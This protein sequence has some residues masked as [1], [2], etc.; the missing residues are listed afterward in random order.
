[1]VT[2]A[3]PYREVVDYLAIHRDQVDAVM[4]TLSYVDGTVFA[5][6][7]TAPALLTVALMDATCPPATVFAAHA[8]YAG[9]AE[10]TIWPHN[11]HEGGGVADDLAAVEFV[12]AR[13]A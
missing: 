9:E 6:R 4:R 13:T 8:R 5:E 12:R 2:D 7:A 10:L 3:Y 11:G 1:M